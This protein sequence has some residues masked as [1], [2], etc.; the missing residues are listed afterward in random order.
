MTHECWWMR[1]RGGRRTARSRERVGTAIAPLHAS[2]LSSLILYANRTSSVVVVAL[3]PHSSQ[4][5]FTAIALTLSHEE[6][7]KQPDLAL[8]SDTLL[9]ITS[10]SDEYKPR[11]HHRITEVSDALLSLILRFGHFSQGACTG[12]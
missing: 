8:I 3:L 9:D 7:L 12:V 5:P 6:T 1:Q 4:A 11:Y 2:S 10:V